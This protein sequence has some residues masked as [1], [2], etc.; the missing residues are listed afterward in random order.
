MSETSIKTQVF[1]S[2][3]PPAVRLRVTAKLFVNLVFFIQMVLKTFEEAY[4]QEITFF[5]LFM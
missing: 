2:L 1:F 4:K 3:L 5:F